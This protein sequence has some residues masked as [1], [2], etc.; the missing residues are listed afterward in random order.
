MRSTGRWGSAVPDSG[1]RA[2]PTALTAPREGR[3]SEHGRLGPLGRG[4]GARHPV[5]MLAGDAKGQEM[6]TDQRPLQHSQDVMRLTSALL[7][8][9]WDS[10]T[11]LTKSL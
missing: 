1:D 5:P 8:V 9:C 10:N 2:R 3:G 11:C 4:C 7:P 6:D